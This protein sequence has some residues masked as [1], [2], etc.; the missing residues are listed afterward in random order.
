MRRAGLRGEHSDGDGSPQM[1]RIHV[2]TWVATSCG[3][4]HESCISDFPS[5]APSACAIFSRKL[6]SKAEIFS[7]IT[8]IT[9]RDSQRPDSHHRQGSALSPSTNFKPHCGLPIF[10]IGEPTNTAP[11]PPKTPRPLSPYHHIARRIAARYRRPEH[12]LAPSDA[13]RTSQSSGDSTSVRDEIRERD[14]GGW[15]A[16]RERWV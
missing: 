6:L 12:L 3:P 14:S 2:R 13:A 11:G 16:R 7:L 4:A 9:S 15:V 8:T 5:G 1:D 10:A